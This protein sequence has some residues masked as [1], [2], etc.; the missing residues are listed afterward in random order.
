MVDLKAVKR[1]ACLAVMMAAQRVV[2]M[3]VMM[4]DKMVVTRAARLAHMRAGQ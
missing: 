3:V 2:M 1:V 4:V